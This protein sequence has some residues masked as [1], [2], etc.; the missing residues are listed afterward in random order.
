MLFYLFLL[1]LINTNKFHWKADKYSE[2][3]LWKVQKSS[4]KYSEKVDK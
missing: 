1:L 4:E 3:V 2:K